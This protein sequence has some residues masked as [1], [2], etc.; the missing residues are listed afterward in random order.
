MTRSEFDE[1][2]QLLRGLDP[3][4]GARIVGAI[5]DYVMPDAYAYRHDGGWRVAAQPE[6]PP[7]AWR[8]TAHYERMVARA[9]ASDGSYLRGRCR[10]RAG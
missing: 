10:R 9:A 8:S 3:R 7:A 6:L 4:P 1:A 5:T 2:D